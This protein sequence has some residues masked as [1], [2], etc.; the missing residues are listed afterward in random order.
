MFNLKLDENHD[1]IIGRGAVRIGGAEQVAQLVKCRI[2]ALYG[3]WE[4]DP[5]LG[6][7]WFEGIFKKNVRLSDVQ[8]ALAN[9][10]R[11]T[12]GVQHLISLDV[13]SDTNSRTLF[14]NFVAFSVY[15]DVKGEVTWQPNMA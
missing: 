9:V 8:T 5:S 14:V 1:I 6:I 10:I 12:N 7:P 13:S 11:Q 15:G 2:L 3:E 4:Q